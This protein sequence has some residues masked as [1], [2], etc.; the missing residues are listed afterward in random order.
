ATRY[1]QE[2]RTI[3]PEGPYLLGGACLGGV[4][5]VEMARQLQAEGEQ[6]AIPILAFDAYLSPERS[7]Q[8]PESY[9]AHS[10]TEYALKRARAHLRESRRLGTVGALRY[11]AGKALRNATEIPSLAAGALRT[12]RAKPDVPPANQEATG[13]E[14]AIEQAQRQLSE[15]FLQAALR[16][17]RDYRPGHLDVDLALFRAAESPDP[18]PGWEAHVTGRIDDHL[19]PGNHLDMMEE[20][21]V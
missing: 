14:T 12:L 5:A 7:A 2:I 9:Q 19:M 16:L 3:Q 1:L 10:M 21:A 8:A 4:I 13:R 20:P 11:L 17:L 15:R 18:R 6:V